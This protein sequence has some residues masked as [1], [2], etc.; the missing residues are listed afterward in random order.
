MVND[1]H[2]QAFVL[3]GG[4]GTRLRPMTH[5]IPKSMAPIKGK[6]ILEH[7]VN[8]LREAGFLDIVLAVGHLKENVMNYFGDGSAF[9]V[10]IKY[11]IEETPLGTGGALKAYGENMRS[12]F[13]M[14]N[15]DNLFDFD[16]SK[17]YQFHAERHPLAT[18]GLTILEDVSQFGVAE[19]EG[20][21]IMKFVEKPKS[22]PHS[23]LINTGIYMINPSLIGM[24]PDGVSN[25]SYEFEH[26]VKDNVINGFVYSGKWMAC[27]TPEL[28]KKASEEWS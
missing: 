5:S 22:N 3:A 1:L 27:D 10:R 25:I 17:I 2:A 8:R 12:D 23:H 6:P 13:I 28:Y 9:G 20:D 18:I 7:I 4:Y 16:L 19:M 14:L 24:L 21:R 15:G 11:A 26:L